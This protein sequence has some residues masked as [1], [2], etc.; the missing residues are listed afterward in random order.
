MVDF[1][2]L[3]NLIYS[4]HGFLN[5]DKKQQTYSIVILVLISLFEIMTCLFIFDCLGR[6]NGDIYIYIYIYIYT[7]THTHT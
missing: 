6:V 2:S 4:I 3:E 1:I 5:P 7:H